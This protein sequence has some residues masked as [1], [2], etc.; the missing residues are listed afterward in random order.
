MG[1]TD[2]PRPIRGALSRL[3]DPRESNHL[4]DYL[5]LKGTNKEGRGLA[6]D[7]GDRCS[8]TLPGEFA[9]KKIGGWGLFI[10]GDN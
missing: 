10:W 4:A 1:N 3:V 7:V 6:R 8:L 5:F 2:V 9:K